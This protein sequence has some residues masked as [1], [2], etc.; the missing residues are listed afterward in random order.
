MKK[1]VSIRGEKLPMN[2]EKF[3]EEIYNHEGLG[4][5]T[6]ITYEGSVFCIEE[7]NSEEGLVYITDFLKVKPCNLWYTGNCVYNYITKFLKETIDII[8]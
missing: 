1:T 4:D 5:I 6:I 8:Y 3:I 2:R 7:V